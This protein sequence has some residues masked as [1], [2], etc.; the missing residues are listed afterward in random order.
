MAAATG[1][2]RTTDLGIGGI[3]IGRLGGASG[4]GW[5]NTNEAKVV[6]A[7]F[8]DTHNA[9]VEQVRALQAKPL[10]PPVPSR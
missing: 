7:A 9:L 4:A 6:A 1:A 10:P 2:A 5:S 3:M 8:L